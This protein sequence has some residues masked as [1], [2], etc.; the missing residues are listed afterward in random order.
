[1]K[2]KSTIAVC[3]GLT[4]TLCSC[5]GDNSP[6]KL[7]EKGQF[8][9]A[10][11]AY[12]EEIKKDDSSP[13]LYIGLADAYMGSGE[14]EAAIDT[15]ADG[16]D[17]TKEKKLSDKMSEIVVSVFETAGD[18]ADFQSVIYCCDRTLECDEKNADIYKISALSYLKTEDTEKAVETA[19]EGLEK[20]EDEGVAE[21]VAS[22]LYTLGSKAF[23]GGQKAEAKKYFNL[24]L[25]LDKDNSDAK[26]ML[27]A[28]GEN[29]VD[30]KPAEKDDEKQEDEPSKEENKPQ[31]KPEVQKPSQTS[32]PEAPAVSEPV[33]TGS[34][35]VQIGL[36]ANE[37]NAKGKVE[38]AKAKGFSASYSNVNG[39]FRVTIGTFSSYADAEAQA[40]KAQ[41]AGF[42]TYII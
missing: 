38:T 5:M 28:I 11:K 18:K 2:L 22:Q 37:E 3:V 10:A 8:D 36:Y 24:V 7:L 1:M 21:A 15:L 16:F 31:A 25:E 12:I 32:A 17:S 40:A 35:T 42:S 14:Y 20:T 27:T 34:Y 13:E 30:K 41:S 39:K 29:P 26:N 19:K 9:A 23:T 6:E 4:L 33:Q